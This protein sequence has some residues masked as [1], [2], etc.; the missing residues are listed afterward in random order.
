[1]QPFRP[2]KPI[3]FSVVIVTE[4]PVII[5]METVIIVVAAFIGETEIN[6]REALKFTGL[7]PER[8]FEAGDITLAQQVKQDLLIRFLMLFGHG[9]PPYGLIE[10][11]FK[12]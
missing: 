7:H 5:V 3:L 12:P 4:K 10:L 2:G 1:M 9:S 8:L 6:S 11:T